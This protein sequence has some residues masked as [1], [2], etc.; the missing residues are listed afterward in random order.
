MSLVDYASSDKEDDEELQ[1]PLREQN[2]QKK[3]KAAAS[4]SPA[5]PREVPTLSRIE[6][7]QAEPPSKKQTLEFSQPSQPCELK[8]PDA[9]FLLNSP[10]MPA[11]LDH[12][13]DHSSCRKMLLFIFCSWFMYYDGNR[14]HIRNTGCLVFESVLDPITILQTLIDR[15]SKTIAVEESK[16]AAGHCRCCFAGGSFVAS[17]LRRRS[18]LTK[19]TADFQNL[20]SMP[21]RKEV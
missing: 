11:N 16:V 15:L 9:S 17:L 2:E 1:E 5:A 14:F 13:S 7:K 8:L 12:A 20:L 6:N 10:S 19:F 3:V 21:A 4:Q 18:R